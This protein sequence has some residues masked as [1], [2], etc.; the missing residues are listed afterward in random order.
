MRGLLVTGIYLLMSVVAFAMYWADKRRAG[1]GGWRI[2]EATLHTIE[3]LGGWPGALA[4]QRVLRHK[5]RKTSYMAVF[6][7]IVA[8]HA[9][10]WAWWLGGARFAGLR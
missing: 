1:S 10:G 2:S 7:T 4:A 8:A 3:L 9:I 5:W 6:W